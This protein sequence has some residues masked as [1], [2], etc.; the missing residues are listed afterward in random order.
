MRYTVKQA[1]SL[2]GIAPDRLR[3]WE[4]RYG[5]VTPD[6]TESRYRLYDDADLARLR[7]MVRL[8]D[9]GMPASLAAEEV[10]AAYADPPPES[11]EAAGGPRRS[12][13]GPTATPAVEALVAPARSLDRSEL[14]QVLDRAFAAEPFET[15]VEHWLLPALVAVGDDW[16][17]GAVDVA[18]EHFVSSAIARRLARVFDAAGGSR[19]GPAV[20]VG[21]PP[22]CLHELG[23]LSFATC[24]RRLGVDVRWMGADLPVESWEHAVGQVDPAAVVLS[25]PTESDAPA[26][27]DVVRRLDTRMPLVCLGGRGAAAVS[28]DAG[29]ST[30]VMVLPFSV[31]EAAQT[32]VDRVRS[33]S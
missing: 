18:G 27:L 2:T 31:V 17:R 1:S 7:L 29:L 30:E 9:S 24:L 14:E 25:V 12:A 10:R 32:V 26:T 6:R 5:V 20:L 22:G 33:V 13:R 11:T 3:A 8:V 21:L 23:S 15:V 16:E 28:L 4:R 19:P